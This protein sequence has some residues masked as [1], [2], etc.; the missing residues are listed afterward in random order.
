MKF[1]LLGASKTGTSIAYHLWKNGYRPV[2][3]WNRSDTNLKKTLDFVPFHQASN[4][5]RQYGKNCDL[6]IISVADNAIETVVNSFFQAHKDQQETSFF[7]TSGSLD[8][9]VFPAA[10]QSG[11]FHPV[12]SIS[13]IEEGIEMIPKTTFTC[14]GKISDKLVK[15]AGQIGKKG[16]PLTP[17]Q[18]QTIHLSAVFMN[19]YLSGMVEKVKEI[20][21]DTG[22][23]KTETEDILAP[24]S[25]QTLRRSWSKDIRETLTGP[26]KRGDTKTIKKHLDIL[27][28]DD[29]FQQLYKIFGNILVKFVNHD[30]ETRKLLEDLLKH[31]INKR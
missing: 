23:S 31:D 24:I 3:L 4:D 27:A 9:F 11:S 12:I 7:H 19:N 30:K 22:I 25:L 1:A 14:E 17:Q 21:A 15:I 20:N 5:I 16:I 18:K 26:I 10:I 2:F 13:S 29:L 8:S 6:V 28:K